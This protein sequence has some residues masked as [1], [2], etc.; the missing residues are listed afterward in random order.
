MLSSI[1]VSW[2]VYYLYSN[3]GS[4]FRL[5][6]LVSFSW[7]LLFFVFFFFLGVFLGLVMRRRVDIDPFLPNM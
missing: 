6:I 3:G 1:L 5:V 4:V 7:L 2:S